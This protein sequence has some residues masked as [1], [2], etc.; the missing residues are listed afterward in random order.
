MADTT[1][2][3][4]TDGVTA[5]AT[6]EIPAI[7]SPFGA[8]NDVK[9]TPAYIAEYIRT[10][11]QTLTNKTLT[12]PTLTAPV[13]GTPA[14]GTLTNCTGLPVSTGI[15]GLATGVATL[16]ATFTSA[17]LAAALTDETGSGAAVFATSPTLVTPLLGTPT[18]G[19]LTNCTG[20]PISTGVSGLGTGVATA[21]ATFSSANIASAC[22]DETGSGALMFGTSPTVTTSLTINEGA[23]SSGLT[24][25]GATQTTS[26]P[27]IN[28]SQTWNAGAVTFTGWKFNVTDTASATGSLFLDCQI[29]GTTKFSVDKTGKITTG[30]GAT[31]GTGATVFAV[32]ASTTGHLQLTGGANF[33]FGDTTN[34]FTG[35]A[36]NQKFGWSSG[37]FANGTY[38]LVMTR[39]AA[40]TLQFGA[41]DA[42]AP[43][44]QTLKFQSVVAG[45]SNTAAV[46]T[47]ITGSL[48]TGSGTGGDI[49]IKT[50][51]T[52]AAATTQNAATSAL[53]IAGATQAV[54]AVSPTGGLGYGTGAG[55]TV[56]Q[57]TSRTTGVTL[58]KVCG[59]ITLVSAAGSTS[60][61]TFTVTNSTVAA[62][63]VIKVSQK[64]GTDKNIILVTAVA[65]G[66]F[67]ITFATTGGTTTEQPVFNFAVIKAVTA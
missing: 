38:D 64:S 13:L 62:T 65:A 60:Y 31:Y 45:T 27:A 44:A 21:L 47:T 54:L 5:N 22:T 33:I 58:N 51:A 39:A 25:T 67:D 56:T 19:T 9:I 35:V 48:S 55:G 49:T 46:T 34:V 40:A 20:L 4:L 2:H 37:S 57:A 26:N 29:A 63:D 30:V 59:A 16:L 66:S 41:A 53:T 50:S 15:S 32:L 14:S 43:V 12:S 36:S 1:I 18:S 28:A 23:G 42:A 3:A 6:D 24:L 10:L 52:G 61:Q 17:N 7:R 11:T 8:G